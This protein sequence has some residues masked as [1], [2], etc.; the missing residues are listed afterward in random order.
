MTGNLDRALGNDRVKRQ[1]KATGLNA[2][3]INYIKSYMFSEFIENYLRLESCY[4]PSG[5]QAHHE[6]GHFLLHVADYGKEQY[7]QIIALNKISEFL[8]THQ[9]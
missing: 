3:R 2:P 6:E 4:C 7:N 9:L 5:S 1:G 8:V